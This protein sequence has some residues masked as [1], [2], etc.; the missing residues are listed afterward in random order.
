MSTLP[1][2]LIAAVVLIALALSL[3]GLEQPA[4]PQAPAE[5]QPRY[6]LKDVQLERYD[7]AGNPLVQAQ[8][9]SVQYFDDASA[10]LKDLSVSGLGGPGAP[11]SAAAP[12]GL[13][14]PGE[15]R[16]R[17]YGP[18]TGTGHW[19]GGE[20][21]DFAT[22]QLWVD[23]RKHEFYTDAPVRLEGEQRRATADGMRADWKLDSV[24]L[25]GSVRMDY[26][27]RN[28]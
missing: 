25:Q 23:D 17:L 6:Y 5:S 3:A 11:W 4:G 9:Q 21:F 16:M 26:A 15:R 20:A 22:D 10:R 2:L 27:S 28:D 24:Q 1:S 13:A 7:A 14:P 12:A 8:A 18:V 19:A